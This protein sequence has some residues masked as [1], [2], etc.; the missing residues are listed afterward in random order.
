[1]Y[2]FLDA[3]RHPKGPL[4]AKIRKISAAWSESG[5]DLLG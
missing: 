1:M 5:G 2:L 4:R 3:N